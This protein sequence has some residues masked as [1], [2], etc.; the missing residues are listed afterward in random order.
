MQT[1]FNKFLHCLDSYLDLLNDSAIVL[2]DETQI[3]I[4]G[5]VTLEN[6][7]IMR[8]TNSYHDKAWFSNIAISMDS[9]ES[10]DY[11]SD[12]GL[13]YGQVFI[14]LCNNNNVFIKAIISIYIL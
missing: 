6:G 4:Y 1:G 7:A 5:S 13:C 8:A 9:E 2:A 14:N 10:N 12:Q 11:I 3:N